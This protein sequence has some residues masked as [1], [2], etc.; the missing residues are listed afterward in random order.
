MTPQ[1]I[2]VYGERTHETF[3]A[4]V[5]PCN[6]HTCPGAF[7]VW[8]APDSANNQRVYTAHVDRATIDQY[9]AEGKAIQWMQNAADMTPR[10]QDR[11]Q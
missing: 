6:E 4:T 5:E 7:I 10:P 1:T 11:N 8:S 9:T 2:T 3:T